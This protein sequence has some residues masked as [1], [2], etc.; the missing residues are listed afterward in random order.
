MKILFSDSTL[1]KNGKNIFSPFSKQY[2]FF[3]WHSVCFPLSLCFNSDSIKNQN[4]VTDVQNEL[5]WYWGFELC[6]SMSLTWRHSRPQMAQCHSSEMRQEQVLIFFFFLLNWVPNEQMK[7]WLVLDVLGDLRE[8]FQGS[9]VW[10][11]VYCNSTFFFF[12]FLRVIVSIML[13]RFGAYIRPIIPYCISIANWSSCLVKIYSW[14]WQE[15]VTIL[16]HILV[17]T[18]ESKQN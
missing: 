11:T 6:L 15:T 8:A 2:P 9:N 4:P 3:C 12:F 1:L 13:L 18:W 7:I 17:G 10:R 5:R 16:Q 14:T